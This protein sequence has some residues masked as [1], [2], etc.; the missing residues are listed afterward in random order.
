MTTTGLS[1]ICRSL[2]PYKFINTP[3]V[4]TTRQIADLRTWIQ[5]DEKISVR[6]LGVPDGANRGYVHFT[7]PPLRLPLTRRHRPGIRPIGR[8]D[9]A[10]PALI[11]PVPFLPLS[12][13]PSFCCATY[14]TPPPIPP[15][16]SGASRADGSS[17]PRLRRSPGGMHRP[18]RGGPPPRQASSTPTATTTTT[19]M[20][21]T[22]TTAIQAARRPTARA[23][24]RRRQGGSATCGLDAT[25]G[26]TSAAGTRYRP[27]PRSRASRP[28]ADPHTRPGG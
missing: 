27:S 28:G 24:P 25:R 18:P 9:A 8:S 22:T 23:R 3:V 12:L 11:R 1:R 5:V 16:W 26:R 4:P 13:P 17:F 7:F 14:H 6:N 20:R 2:F 10:G 21:D 19:P 15:P